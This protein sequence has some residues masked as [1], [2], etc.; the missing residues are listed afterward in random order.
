MNLCTH[1][2]FNILEVGILEVEGKDRKI[3]K[4]TMPSDKTKVSH[5]MEYDSI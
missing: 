5:F 3:M 1:T 4:L 2:Q